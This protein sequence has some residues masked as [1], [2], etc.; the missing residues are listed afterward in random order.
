MTR[1]S[2]KAEKRAICPRKLKPSFAKK[3]GTKKDNLS[4]GF[5]VKINALNSKQ[6]FIPKVK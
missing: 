6:I 1:I 4:D 3:T 2:K 5:K